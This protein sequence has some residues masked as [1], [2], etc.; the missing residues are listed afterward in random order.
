M[1]FTKDAVPETGKLVLV[2]TNKG[3]WHIAKYVLHTSKHNFAHWL[4]GND[5]VALTLYSYWQELPE[6]PAF[7]CEEI[8]SKAIESRYSGVSIQWKCSK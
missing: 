2:S 8:E 5:A 6:A 3:Q 4:E 7:P 1:P